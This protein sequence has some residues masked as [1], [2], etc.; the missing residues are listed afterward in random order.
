SRSSVT[1]QHLHQLCCICPDQW[2]HCSVCQC[3]YRWSHR[4]VYC[5]PDYWSLSL[6]ASLVY[7]EKVSGSTGGAGSLYVVFT[8][9]GTS[10][11][12]SG[13]S[14]GVEHGRKIRSTL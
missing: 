5:R 13:I 14:G 1:H 4:R 7:T 10:P 9:A 12:L 11:I 3:R 6:P 2:S 8:A